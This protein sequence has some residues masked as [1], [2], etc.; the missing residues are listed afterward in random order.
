M[1][2]GTRD[3]YQ[4]PKQTRHTFG[5]SSRAT[6]D[7]ISI[8]RGNSPFLHIPSIGFRANQGYHNDEWVEGTKSRPSVQVAI[9]GD[10]TSSI[11]GHLKYLVGVPNIRKRYY[12]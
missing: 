12:Q 1:V 7:T 9:L 3:P 2:T 6:E 10:A 11:K 5:K 8:L 4:T